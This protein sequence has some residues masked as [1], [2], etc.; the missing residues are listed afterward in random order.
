ML[1]KIPIFILVLIACFQFACKKETEEKL[2]LELVDLPIAIV[3]SPTSVE[4]NWVTNLP[5]NSVVYY[6]LTDVLG[7]TARDEEEREL[8]TIILTGL[9]SDTDYYYMVESSSDYFSK[10]PQSDLLQF[11]TT[12]IDTVSGD[13]EIVSGPDVVQIDPVSVEINWETNYPG[14]SVVYYGVTTMLGDTI[15]DNEERQFHTVILGDLLPDTVYYFKVESKSDYFSGSPQSTQSQFATQAN[16]ES[17][18]VYGWSYFSQGEYID[19]LNSFNDAINLNSEYGPAYAGL[20]WVY[21]RMENYTSA[22]EDF[23]TGLGYDITLLEIYAGR[24]LIYLIQQSYPEA[25]NDA[26][27]VINADSTYQFEYAAGINYILMR[28][29][30]SQAYYATQEY[31]LAQEQCDMI[32][33]ENGLDPVLPG[34]WVVN[35]V[36]YDTY[37]EALLGLIQY[38]VLQQGGG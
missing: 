35:D 15:S 19:A 1:K 10:I 20:G 18:M 36:T 38:L 21:L 3:T 23:D 24:S 17:Y 13:L 16:E 22:L 25:I 9:A 26:Q 30:M 4:I 37:V 27:I 12:W 2:E 29:V 5:A 31:Q 33:P 14:N 28:L 34:T 7:D 32:D 6:G 11:N 8:H